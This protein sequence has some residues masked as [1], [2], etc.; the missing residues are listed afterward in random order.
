M[1]Q[2]FVELVDRVFP[3]AREHVLEPGEGIDLQ[4]FARPDK[5]AEDRHGLAAPV[6]AYE[7]PVVAANSDTAQASLGVVVVD[8]EIAVFAIGL[9]CKLKPTERS[10]ELRLVE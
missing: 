10:V 6:A 9:W 4:Q 3:D 1:R 7:Q 2:Q 5:A 8:R